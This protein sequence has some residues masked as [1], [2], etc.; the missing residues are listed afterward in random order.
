MSQLHLERLVLGQ[1]ETNCYILWDEPSGAAVVVDPADSGETILQRCLDL[2]LAV[3]AI[4]LTHAHFDHVLALLE[5]KL[6]WDV[7]IFLHQADQELL[8]QAQSSAQHWLKHSVDPVP[9]A[10]HFWHGGETIPL[11]ETPFHVLHTP[12]HT[13]G[14]VCLVSNQLILTGDTLFAEGVG[15]TDFSYSR[16]LQLNTSLRELA[17]LGPQLP[18]YPGHGDSIALGMALS[19]V[20]F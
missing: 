2:G 4:W 13:P 12:G 19:N 1:L 14:S 10:T 8:S 3:G 15:R 16:P 11:G 18:I 5:L 9:P 17:Q 6:A 7:P 20:G